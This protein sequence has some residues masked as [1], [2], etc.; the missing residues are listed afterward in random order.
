VLFAASIASALQ[1]PPRILGIAD[2]AFR[3]SV[4][5]KSRAFYEDLLGFA[6][7]FSLT[8]PGGSLSL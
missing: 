1:A 6:K 2:A 3:F 7:P 5:E 8:N 4:I